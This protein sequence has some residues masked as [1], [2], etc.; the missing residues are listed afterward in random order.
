MLSQSG[1]SIIIDPGSFTDAN[2]IEAALKTA[3]EIV[4]VV[5]T[6]E[7]ADHWTA[8]N[9]AAIRKV[10][11]CPVF[12][13][14]ATADALT[15][16][17]FDSVQTVI[18][19]DVKTAGSFELEF[20]GHKHE[21]LHT[22]L[23]IVDNVGVFVNRTLAFGGDSL[24]RPP[25]TN[26]PVLGVPIGSPWSNLTQVLTF[27]ENMTLNKIYFTHDSLLSEAGKGLYVTR[28]TEIAKE[29]GFE[30]I[31]LPHVTKNPGETITLA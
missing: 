7:H 12:T 21:L 16:A 23:P 19:G 2:E 1:Q 25:F 31:H 13:T 29:R 30:I 9:I 11:E 15:A 27:V 24:A 10:S 14:K 8:D 18:E 26:I 20:Y 17:G 22:N 5:I 28:I 6:H 4:A 3:D